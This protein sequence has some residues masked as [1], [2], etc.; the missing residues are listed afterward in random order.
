MKK[1]FYKGKVYIIPNGA[2]PIKIIQQIE[3]VEQKRH[4]F[5]PIKREEEE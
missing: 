2:P 4:L 1:V 5:K 3:R